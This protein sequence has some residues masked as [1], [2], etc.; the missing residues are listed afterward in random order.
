MG[1]MEKNNIMNPNFIE[2]LEEQEYDFN[3]VGPRARYTVKWEVSRYTIKWE[4]SW[5]IKSVH[6]S[7]FPMEIHECDSYSW[8]RVLTNNFGM[9]EPELY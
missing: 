6:D 4:V 9:D 7:I 2:W 5:F 3:Y 8:S 1:I